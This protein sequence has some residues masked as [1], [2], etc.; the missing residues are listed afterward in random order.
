MLKYSIFKINKFYYK[1]LNNCMQ[2]N[3]KD[4]LGYRFEKY[5]NKGEASIFV[6]LFVVFIVFFLTIIGINMLVLHFFSPGLDSNYLGI[7]DAIWRTWLQMT[8][9]AN[10]SQDNKMSLW[11]KVFTVLAGVVGVIIL[12]SLIAFITTS[13]EMIFYNFRKGRGLVIENGHTL[14][15]A[16]LSEEPLINRLHDD[17]LSEDGS[18]IYVKSTDL[19]SSE[20]PQ[21]VS[22]AD[23]I[24]L[25]AKRDEVCLGIRKGNL[26]K[27]GNFNFGVRL[28]LS[29]DE[30][31]GSV[32]S[33]LS[34]T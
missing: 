34:K 25:A 31:V 24:G 33:K 29:K 11:T 7:N 22:F 30:N 28:N 15:L 2:I 12:S 23:L 8:E 10:R 1:L 5:L 9:S 20:F 32:T 3:F 4:Q 19:Y 14:I 21:T 27:D 16:Q 17:L 26:S 6:S 13:L 18:E